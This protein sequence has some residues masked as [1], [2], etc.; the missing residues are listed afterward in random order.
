MTE[1]AAPHIRN[2]PGGITPVELKRSKTELPVSCGNCNQPF[3]PK[4]LTNWHGK[5][6]CR[7]CYD[8]EERSRKTQSLMVVVK[9]LL[10]RRIDSA[11]KDPN[12]AEG[13]IELNTARKAFLAE[14]GGET[15]FGSAW[16]RL[17]K[18]VYDRAVMENKNVNV[19]AKMFAD[20]AK[21]LEAA[22]DREVIGF[23]KL[24]LEQMK[25]QQALALEAHMRDQAASEAMLRIL[26]LTEAAAMGGADMDELIVK[27]DRML[28]TSRAPQRIAQSEGL[29]T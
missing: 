9:E 24:T 2:L 3:R 25:E 1:E 20:A 16:A 15:T 6:L 23:A 19:A 8:H 28:G 11:G 7:E 10:T 14:F 13:T 18:H 4:E 27:F 22:K 5:R 29:S 12:A 21:F 17:V 26:E